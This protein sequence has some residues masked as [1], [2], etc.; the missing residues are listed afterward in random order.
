MKYE[1]YETLAK[2]VTADTALDV[3]RSMLEKAQTDA[4]DYDAE[5]A[6]LND[7]ITESNNKY[8]DLQVDY[9]KKFT[10][11]SADDA[12]SKENEVDVDAEIEDIM[13]NI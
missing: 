8:K 6:A 2:D 4:V 3:V 9:I 7:K 13:K 12:E 5:I 1:D 11:E 10:S